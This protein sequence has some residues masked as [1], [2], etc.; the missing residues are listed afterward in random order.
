MPHTSLERGLTIS[1]AAVIVVVLAF[2]PI[3]YFAMQGLAQKTQV[4]REA[5]MHGQLAYERVVSDADGLR[6]AIFEAATDPDPAAAAASLDRAKALGRRFPDD[7]RTMLAIFCR[8]RTNANA[9]GPDCSAVGDR[10]RAEVAALADSFSFTAGTYRL[11]ALSTISLLDAGNKAAALKQINGSSSDAYLKQNANGQLMLDALNRYADGRFDVL[12]E[13]RNDIS[14]IILICSLFAVSIVICALGWFRA[15]TLRSVGRV[16]DAFEAMGN[17]DLT[18]RIAWHGRDLLGRVGVAVDDLSGRWAAII[19]QIQTASTTVHRASEQSNHISR[20]V[21]GRVKQE[22]SAL[23]EALTYSRN[24]GTAAGSVAENADGVAQRVSD[25]SS[26]VTQMSASIHEMDRNLVSLASVVEQAVASTQEMS[27]SITQVAVNAER[28]RSESTL[29]DRQVREGHTEVLAL[30]KGM[31][32]IRD[33][34]ADVVTEMKS[35]DYASRQIGEILSLIETIADQT[36]LLA[37]NAAIEAA[38]AGEHGRGFAVVA[39][40]VRKLAEN[41]AKSTKD[42]AALVVDIQR[43]TSAVLSRAARASDLLTH[44]AESVRSVALTIEA[45]SARVAEVAQVIREISAATTEQAR[46]SGE[47]AEASQQMGAMTHEAAAT[48]REQTLT[49]NQ[50]LQSVTEI[51]DRTAQV[52]RASIEQ[53]AAIAA[54]GLRVQRSSDLGAENSEAIRG[55]TDAADQVRSQA[56]ALREMVG[57]FHT[58]QPAAISP[59]RSEASGTRPL[60]GPEA[61]A[62]PS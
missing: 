38:R 9:A 47:L 4:L 8:V 51:E 21:D 24:L 62:L 49:S 30:S 18:Q 53:R 29:T 57:Q 6:V 27:A 2:F 10:S 60:E 48:M 22:L 34:F 28:V 52:A 23:G 26:A 59:A 1:F 5:V 42:I 54:L 12:T 58:G 20:E 46:A 3:T 14:G 35:L 33:A 45:I 43:R 11:D 36:N 39:D 7:A 41:S 40:E 13:A 15:T 37:L 17:G 32:G 16:V 56:T 25:I 19:A 61:L 50:I 31:N 44:N 55:M